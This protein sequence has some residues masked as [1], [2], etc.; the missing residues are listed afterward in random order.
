MAWLIH[1]MEESI[2]ETFLFHPIA[3]DIWE[4]VSL[5]YSDLEDSS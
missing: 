3:K 5:V 4:A 2:G 1:S